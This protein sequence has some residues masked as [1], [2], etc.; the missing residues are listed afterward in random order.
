MSRDFS[1]INIQNTGSESPSSQDNTQP[2]LDGG[3]TK[4]KSGSKF[5]ERYGPGVKPTTGTTTDL[6]MSS[7][8]P[9]ID[10][11]KSHESLQ[12]QDFYKEHKIIALCMLS[13]LSHLLQPLD[14]GC[15]SPLKTAYGKQGLMRN[16]INHITKLEFLSAFRVAFEVLITPEYGWRLSR[17]RSR[18]IRLRGCYIRAGY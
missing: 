8:G 17:H 12:I 15:F 9:G 6:G 13:H 18:P 10:G 4:H 3:E 7:A 1:T 11:H 16:R 5:N 2:V 14:V